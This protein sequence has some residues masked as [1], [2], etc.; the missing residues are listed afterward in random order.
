M[1]RIVIEVDAPVGQAI[2]VKEDFAMYLERF[3]DSRVVEVQEVAQEQMTM[4]KIAQ[5]YAWLEENGLRVPS[6]LQAD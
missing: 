6:N 3:G 2:G 4:D 1:L 5:A